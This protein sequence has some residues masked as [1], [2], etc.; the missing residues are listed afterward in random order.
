MST[1][2]TP[3]S[4]ELLD[5]LLSAQEAFFS[6]FGLPENADHV[7]DLRHVVWN[8]D[9]GVMWWSANGHVQD[10]RYA[11]SDYRRQDG[12]TLV[13]GK[14]RGVWAWFVFDE[15]KVDASLEW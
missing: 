3:K 15:M 11:S 14:S 7:I 10:V 13:R 6:E 4:H 2:K 8:G 9:H 12:L 1:D 5:A